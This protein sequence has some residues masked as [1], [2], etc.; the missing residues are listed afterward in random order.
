M[1]ISLVNALEDVELEAGQTYRCEVRGHQIELRVLAERAVD[2]RD[3]STALS[4]SDVML[5]AWCEL[6][7]PTPIRR[8]K[9]RLVASLPIDIPYI[10]AEEESAP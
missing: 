10:P 3:E 4:E 6:P 8:V 1:S 7:G 9:S 2:H 5:D